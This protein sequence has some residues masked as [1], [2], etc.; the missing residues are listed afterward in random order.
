V[1]DA[2]YSEFYNLFKQL[3]HEGGGMRDPNA[4]PPPQRQAPT[5]WSIHRVCVDWKSVLPGRAPNRG[6]GAQSARVSFGLH[7]QTHKR[8][9]SHDLNLLFRR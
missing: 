7:L 5:P 1:S 6:G 4:K 8:R 3:E 9:Y 2:A